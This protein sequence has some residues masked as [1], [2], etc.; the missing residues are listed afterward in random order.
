MNF[1]SKRLSIEEEEA[2]NSMIK[3]LEAE[4][5]PEFIDAAKPLFGVM[6]PRFNIR[7]FANEVIETYHN[8]RP[9]SY[10]KADEYSVRL[11]KMIRESKPG[12]NIRLLL[13]SLAIVCPHSMTVERVVSYH[14]ILKTS[15]RDSMELDT[16][17]DRLLIVLPAHH[18]LT[19]GRL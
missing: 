16:I 6:P 1:L 13:S 15:R 18:V 3:L 12:G 2:V 7:D 4:S 8:I 14:N 9:A 10:I 19:R 17:N 5:A 11:Y